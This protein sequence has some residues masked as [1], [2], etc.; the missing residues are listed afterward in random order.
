M[1]AT[2][3]E[4]ATSKLSVKEYWALPCPTYSSNILSF[5]LSITSVSCL[6]G[7]KVLFSSKIDYTNKYFNREDDA[8]GAINSHKI[9]V[10]M[11]LW[12]YF[13]ATEYMQTQN[14]KNK[15]T[16]QNKTKKKKKKHEEHKSKLEQKIT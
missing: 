6:I 14:K 5:I 11:N 10:T 3:L 4:I 2:T 15:K 16:K 12:I 13:L 7:L 8:Q 1:A 9:E